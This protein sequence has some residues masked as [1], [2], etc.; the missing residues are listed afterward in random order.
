VVLLAWAAL[1]ACGGST[2]EDATPDG[3]AGTES[4]TDD[5]AGDD[6]SDDGAERTTT[7][8]D[9]ETLP[10]IDR[11]YANW[12]QERA[13]EQQREVEQ[14][15][16][17]CMRGLGWQYTPVDYSQ[18]DSVGPE[19]DP[20]EFRE[21]WGYGI[22]TFIGREDENPYN[23]FGPG[24]EFVDP[25][26]D[27]VTSLSEAEQ[28]AYYED[29]YGKWDDAPVEEGEMG[30]TE[31]LVK[32][33]QQT[34]SEEVNGEDIYND[35]VASEKLNEMYESMYSDPRIEELYVD[36]AACMNEEG[37]EQ[38]SKPDEVYEYFNEQAME[39]QGG[40]GGFFTETTVAVS[41]GEGAPLPGDDAGGDGEDGT[42]PTTASQEEI[43]AVQEE[44]VAVA[45]AD[46]ACQQEHVVEQMRV[47]HTEIQEQFI[48]ENPDIYAA[49][50]RQAGQ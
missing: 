46:W 41:A 35:P 44:E 38:F 15:M 29:L 33:C 9:P 14:L 13:N 49:M 47:I 22:T 42:T 45:N 20:D 24:D 30:P 16:A 28:Q 37:F 4:A 40:Q 7:T 48:A 21:Q 8:I 25:N 23:S 19:I 18:F 50:Q 36:W 17:T 27:Y 43:D 11:L 31:P 32:G 5:E 6:A 1:G 12:D 39:L 2:S 34:A 26:Q 3:D 10:P